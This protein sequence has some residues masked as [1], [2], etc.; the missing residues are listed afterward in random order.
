[1]K[2]G[3]I[4]MKLSKKGATTLAAMLVIF[5]ITSGLM[6]SRVEKI[7]SSYDEQSKQLELLKEEY[8]SISNELETE[9]AER[10]KYQ[11]LYDHVSVENNQLQEK[12]E[13]LSK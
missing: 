13:E 3:E 1:M 2:Q 5:L 9:K 8:N 11:N 12:I 7:E 6:L 10:V 4:A